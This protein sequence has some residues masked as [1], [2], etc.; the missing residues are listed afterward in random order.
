MTSERLKPF[1]EQEDYIKD[2]V[3]HGIEQYRKGW[4]TLRVVDNEKNSVSGAK[5]TIRQKSHASSSMPICLLWVK[6]KMTSRIGNMN[7]FLRAV[8]I[9]QH[10][11]S[12]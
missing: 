6:W 1:L 12:E 5:V 10:F 11:L 3:S 7:G 4:F 8:S 2:R 9:W